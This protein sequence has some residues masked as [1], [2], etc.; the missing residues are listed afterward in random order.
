MKSMQMTP[1]ALNVLP[2]CQGAIL[3]CAFPHSVSSLKL[4]TTDLFLS[5]ML[6][7][8]YRKRLFLF[9]SVVP[10]HVVAEALP[11]VAPSMEFPQ[12]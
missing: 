4:K 1:A 2:C 5:K 7:K 8:I 10:L 9:L 11:L 6:Q 3:L 12:N